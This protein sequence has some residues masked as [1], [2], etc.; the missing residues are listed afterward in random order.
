M[1]FRSIEPIMLPKARALVD[2]HR[3]RG[4]LCAM[5]TATNS[6]ITRPIASA[7][8]I[9]HLIATVPEERDGRFTGKPS[10][11][12]CFREGKITCLEQWLNTQGKRI[13]GF[14]QSSFY[15]DS[16]NDI[17]LLERVTV[18]VAVDPDPTLE[19]VARERGWQVMSLK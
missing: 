11:T 5:V 3:E 12:P 9:E 4:D 10:G 8:G 16:Q 2:S 14:V 15:S 13:A 18:P 7:F 6:F 17:A 19:R 1:L